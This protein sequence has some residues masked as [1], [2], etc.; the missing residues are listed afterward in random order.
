M[1]KGVRVCV[2]VGA[3]QGAHKE[4]AKLIRSQLDSSAFPGYITS[5]QW[6]GGGDRAQVGGMGVNHFTSRII[7]VQHL[8]NLCLLVPLVRHKRARKETSK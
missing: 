1:C 3:F 6:G 7:K 8:H 5:G 4:L 2:C